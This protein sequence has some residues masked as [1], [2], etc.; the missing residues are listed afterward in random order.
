M[1]NIHEHAVLS[2]LLTPRGSGFVASHGDELLMANNAQWIGFSVEVG[3]DGALYVLDWHDPDITGGSVPGKDTG[4][5][6]RII[7][8][9]TQAVD[10]PSRYD[11]IA[12]MTDRRL[13][14]MQ[15]SP[16][17]W[18]AR[19]TRLELQERAVDREIDPVARQALFELFE[20]V[21]EPVELR[22]R[23]M[24]ALH[25]SGGV[26]GERLQRALGDPQ[27]YVRGWAVQLLTEEGDPGRDVVGRFEAMARSDASP[28]V[29]K[30][31][32]AA[33]QRLEE[34]SRWE[35]ARGLMSRSEDAQDHNIPRLVWY[36]VEPLVAEEATRAL[37]VAGESRIP[38][39]AELIARRTVD[40][41]SLAA[42]VMALDRQPAAR[43]A[44]LRGMRIALEGRSDVGSPPGWERVLPRLESDP[45]A[46]E[47]AGEVAQLLGDAQ[48]TQRNLA[49]LRDSSAATEG[50]RRALTALALRQRPE[51]MDQLP[52][53]L[54]VPELRIAAIRA[55]A[56]YDSGMLGD[57]VLALYD[58]LDE[59]GRREAV[60][61]LASRPVYGR[62]LTAAIRDERVPRRD[63]PAD[64]ARQLRR[65]VGSGFVEVWGL[66]DLD[67]AEE[68]AA[69]SHYRSLLAEEAIR[70]MDP[71]AGREV[72]RRTCGACHVLFG[73]GGEVG[74]E[75]TGTSR[76]N[77]EWM[78]ANILNPSEVIQDDYRLVVVTMRDGRTHM[79]NVIAEDERQLTLRVV[80]QPP[81][82]LATADVQSR[83]VS[84]VSLMPDGLL[85]GLSDEEVLAL[86][87]YLRRGD[88]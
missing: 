26:G 35:L 61:T 36:G 18:H 77:V 83:E 20:G 15:V 60:Q 88:E 13:A 87:A 76:G 81:L 55:V 47:M 40:A 39:L 51:L 62:Q 52:A 85:R 25:V 53:L 59:A 19:R 31:L 14:E 12:K 5:I 29:R 27:E 23:G 70:G 9:V 72:Y 71:A 2:D 30:Y 38:L 67:S 16:S 11:D 86:F 75:L 48:A 4:R 33:L 45:A 21:E 1:A 24:W 3:P 44:M 82:V 58:Q 37:G 69:Y 6:Y 50:R 41:D 56:S 46:R 43:P 66:I 80:G 22:L 28:V 34:G 79:G 32:A 8:E 64:V 7:P 84:G 42:L 73:E 65:V 63:V 74:P 68:Q 57:S 10:F 78:L 49:I 17:D 54:R